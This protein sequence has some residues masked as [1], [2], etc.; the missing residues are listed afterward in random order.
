VQ[1]TREINRLL[2]GILIAFACVALA[3]AFWAVTGAESILRRS[4]NPRRVE[5]EAAIR[6]GA[7]LDRDDEPLV[8]SEPA[9]NGFMTRRYLEPSMSSALG[10]YSLRY[11]VAGVEAA[12]DAQ[13]RGSDRPRDA[14]TFIT[15]GLLHRPQ[16]GSDIRLTLDLDIQRVLAD[17]LEGRR[18]AAVVLGV[19]D[20]FNGDILAMV[21][22]PTFEP[23]TLD[24]NWEQ[25]TADSGQ[26]FFN[27]VLQGAYQPGAA[28]QTVLIS[29]AVLVGA[30]L[31]TPMENATAPVTVDGVTLSCAFPLPEMA[32]SLR[33][34]Y[35]FACPAPF[36]SLAQT[37]GVSTFEAALETFRL[38][39]PP[40][41]PGFAPLPDLAA[42][43]DPRTMSEADLVEN[44]LG[45]G[46]LTVSPLAMAVIAGGIVNDGNAP[47]P[48]LLASVHPPETTSW[49]PAQ[50]IN[51]TVPI[52]TA[53]TASAL[54][55]LMR[56]AVIQGA[57]GN[58]A[59][60]GID[61]GGHVAQAFAGDQS[62][63]WFIGFAEL[64]DR[65]AVA[66]AVVLE[67]SADLGLAADIGG[68]ALAA[69]DAALTQP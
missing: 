29:A 49:L 6:R 30:P 34:A 40:A 17:A 28:L 59:R 26:P 2:K 33:E 61:I 39:Q 37:L 3:A 56:G 45:Q 7:I 36:V 63:A 41:L 12:Y 11:G 38:D 57:A 58:A 69:A 53:N 18:G 43:P 54:Q 24:Q 46:S 16:V 52:A 50:A 21:S 14:L 31:E 35:A 5:A 8:I 55:D 23:N 27:R 25:L 10:Y 19:G 1:F 47:Q 13:L 32:F 9:A 68:T 44:A 66:V 42:T 48:R 60:D 15:D 20:A 67:D 65:R 64:D 62:L 22:N 4:D 51:P